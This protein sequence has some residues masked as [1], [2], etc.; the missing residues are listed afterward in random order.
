ML[1]DRV[2]VAG[3]RRRW[4]QLVLGT[5]LRCAIVLLS[6]AG[7]IFEGGI[8]VVGSLGLVLVIVE[9]VADRLSDRRARLANLCASSALVLLTVVLALHTTPAVLLLLLVPSYRAGDQHGRRAALAV[10]AFL[11]AGLALGT[12][13]LL[14]SP[15]PSGSP[16]WVPRTRH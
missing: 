1:Y 14:P 12:R 11:G 7:A 5:R 16:P 4:W 15:A 13:A 3:A 8:L 9:M 10:P 2:V 6:I